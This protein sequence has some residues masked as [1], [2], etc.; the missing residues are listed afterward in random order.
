[1]LSVLRREKE[2]QLA[3]L[4]ESETL[5]LLELDK[6]ESYEANDHQAGTVTQGVRLG[7]MNFVSCFFA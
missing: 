2:L 3:I 7:A 6:L 1:M 5:Q 4:P